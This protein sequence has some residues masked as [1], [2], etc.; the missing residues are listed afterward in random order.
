MSREPINRYLDS[1]VLKPDLPRRDAEAAIRV[2]VE[3][4]VRTVCVRPWDI[5][6]AAA[7][8]RDTETE[9]SCVL[10]FPHGATTSAIKA[11]EARHYIAAGARELDM[12]VNFGLIRSGLWD[13][14]VADIRGVTDAAHPHGVLVKVIL[15]TVYLN[16]DQIRRGTQCAIQAGADF[17]KTSTGFAPEGDTEAAMRIMLETAA[18]RIQVKPSGGIRDKAKADRFVEL[19]AARL[20]VNYTSLEAICGSGGSGDV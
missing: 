6:L 18:G 2:G 9:V 1:A 19:G 11:L 7:L 16:A 14:V 17:V 10:A 20:G 3:Y 5:E 8:C 13:E 4:R 15:E 12:V